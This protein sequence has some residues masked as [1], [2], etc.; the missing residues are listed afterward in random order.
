M[1][2][3]IKLVLSVQM[4]HERRYAGD[5]LFRRDTVDIALKRRADVFQRTV[6]VDVR[7][8]HEPVTVSRSI[9]CRIPLNERERP[10]IVTC[11]NLSV[12]HFHHRA[13]ETTTT[14]SRV[15]YSA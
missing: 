2:N 13:H 1:A 4:L 12:I 9:A 7:Q 5:H 11:Y 15:F 6:L 14:S 8:R 3:V 10:T